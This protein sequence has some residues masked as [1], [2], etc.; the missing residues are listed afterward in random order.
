MPIDITKGEEPVEV[1]VSKAPVELVETVVVVVVNQHSKY[2]NSSLD[3]YPFKC[4]TP[5]NRI[6][7]EDVIL[8]ALR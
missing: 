5:N 3:R 4:P 7:G 6:D 1:P 2:N 8:L